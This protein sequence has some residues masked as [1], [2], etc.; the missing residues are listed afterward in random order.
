ML[1]EPVGR[2]DHQSVDSTPRPSPPTRRTLITQGQGLALM[3][4]LQP[5]IRRYSRCCS[6]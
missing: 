1:L 6:G 5:P 4:L 3:A 2:P